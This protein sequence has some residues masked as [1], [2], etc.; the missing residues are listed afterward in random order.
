M[1]SMCWMLR[2]SFR[3]CKAGESGWSFESGKTY[4]GLCG[5]AFHHHASCVGDAAFSGI[6]EDSMEGGGNHH[7]EEKADTGVYGTDCPVR[8]LD[9]LLF[10][11]ER[12]GY[13]VC[14]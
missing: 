10:L 12:Q 7:T 2:R 13:C 1:C 5:G 6:K 3:P 14:Q 11:S 9:W 4:F 8:F